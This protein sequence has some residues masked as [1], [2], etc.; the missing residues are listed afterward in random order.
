MAVRFSPKNKAFPDVWEL[1]KRL[2]SGLNTWLKTHV[3]V[4]WI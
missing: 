4:G 2:E 3:L 1:S